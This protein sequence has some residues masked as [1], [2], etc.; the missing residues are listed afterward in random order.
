MP[1]GGRPPLEPAARR[2]GSAWDAFQ[3]PQAQAGAGSAGAGAAADD[4]LT[5]RSWRPM[6]AYMALVVMPHPCSR[7]TLTYPLSPQYVL[8][9]FCAS[10]RTPDVNSVHV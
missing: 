4:A 1:A 5:S 10:S 2:P 3:L 8:Q 7:D 6:I 9:E